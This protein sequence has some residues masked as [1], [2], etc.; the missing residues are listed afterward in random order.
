MHEVGRQRGDQRFA[1]AGGHLRD[2]T[3]VKH[4]AAH[5]LHVEVPHLHVSSGR[6]PDDRESLGQNVLGIRSGFDGGLK[7]RRLGLERFVVERFDLLFELARLQS[8]RHVD[9]LD[10]PLVA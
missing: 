8:D 7:F 4:I 5:K 9:V 10:E 2:L 1:F 6:F 3:L